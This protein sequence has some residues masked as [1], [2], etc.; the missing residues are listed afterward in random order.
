MSRIEAIKI[1]VK[2]QEEI[3]AYKI[4]QIIEDI[5]KELQ[6]IG[7]LEITLLYK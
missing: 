4:T 3:T 7:K 5:N 2:P 1:T 6:K